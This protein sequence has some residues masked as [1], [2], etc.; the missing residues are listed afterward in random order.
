MRSRWLTRRSQCVDT[1][2]DEVLWPSVD[3]MF[4][5]DKLG[6]VAKET[7]GKRDTLRISTVVAKQARLRQWREC[8]R[9]PC[10]RTA[11]AAA[12]P[13]H[14]QRSSEPKD[15]VEVSEGLPT[16]CDSDRVQATLRYGRV[17]VTCILSQLLQVRSG[18]AARLDCNNVQYSVMKG[19]TTVN[20]QSIASG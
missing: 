17:G 14:R 8:L 16:Q 5:Q 6:T 12:T 3:R 9:K 2:V 11:A 7:K 18:G 13:C 15:A 4:H 10:Q 1:H 20:R 19:N